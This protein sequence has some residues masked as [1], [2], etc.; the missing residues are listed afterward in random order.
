MI[1]VLGVLLHNCVDL[2][3]HRL[4]FV[5]QLRQLL[6]V[7]RVFVDVVLRCRLVRPN[8]FLSL[9]FVAKGTW[10]FLNVRRPVTFGRPVRHSAEC[11][12]EDIDL[13]DKLLQIGPV[14]GLPELAEF[15]I[16]AALQLSRRCL[17]HEFMFD[18]IADGL[19]LDHLQLYVDSDCAARRNDSLNWLDHK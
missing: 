10:P 5:L 9:V 3:L 8:L 11:A 14:L 4:D 1:A 17:N 6:H 18:N 13:Q 7:V 15:V 12:V 16:L 19:H 2:R